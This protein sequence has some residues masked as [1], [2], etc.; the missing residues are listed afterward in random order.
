MKSNSVKDF[1]R[2]AFRIGKFV[3]KILLFLILLPLILIWIAARVWLH[4]FVLKKQLVKS[5]MPKKQARQLAK[6][7][8]LKNVFGK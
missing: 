8:K 7:V 3:V 6:Q 4:R 5:G 2:A 1:M